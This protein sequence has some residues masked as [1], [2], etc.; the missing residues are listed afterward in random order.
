M[1]SALI[2]QFLRHVL[3]K[4][5]KKRLV[6]HV[7]TL[8]SRMFISMRLLLFF[9]LLLPFFS[10]SAWAAEKQDSQNDIK[11]VIA[12][13]KILIGEDL[14]KSLAKSIA[15]NNARRS[16]LEQAVG[17]NLHSNTLLYNGEI[18]SDL[19]N[20]ATKGL[21][22]DEKIE[23]WC[24]AEYCY[25]K[26]EAHVRPLKGEG[27]SRMK[28][29]KSVVQRPDMEGSVNSLV[30][31]NN[32]EIQVRVSLHEDSYLHVFSVDQ[33][34]N[35]SKLLPNKYFRDEIVPARKEFIF[36]DDS[37]RSRGLKLRVITPKNL[38][39]AYETI[40]IVATRGKEHFL[41]E[42]SSESPTITDLM[43]ELA[44]LDQSQWVEKAIGY[45][46]RK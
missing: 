39:R 19:I 23:N 14:T 16:A 18:I 22:V 21:I 28:F 8:K 1:S 4:A 36:P 38:G 15:L 45:E 2:C 35:I 41:D 34:G 5:N 7:V 40:L 20:S 3:T 17:V 6:D 43:K 46:V 26:I 13:G 42:A 9:L 24:D 33:Y 10:V 32:D 37:L 31:Q 11:A 29:R 25:A 30:F 12:E 44:E 27:A